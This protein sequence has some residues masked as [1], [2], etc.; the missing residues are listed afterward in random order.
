MSWGGRLKTAREWFW[1]AVPH[2]H[3]PCTGPRGILTWCSRCGTILAIE[4]PAPPGRPCEY[5]G[6]PLPDG[7]PAGQRFCK[8]SH[9]IAAKRK[10]NGRPVREQRKVEAAWSL[11]GTKESHAVSCKRKASYEQLGDALVALNWLRRDTGLEGA[12]LYTCLNCGKFHITSH[13]HG[14]FEEAE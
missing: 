2:K 7:A 1:L 11:N 12:A 5:C 6:G 3:S 10:R 9:R 4:D 14:H 8:P 13:A